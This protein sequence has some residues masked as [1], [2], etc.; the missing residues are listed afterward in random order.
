MVKT[1][2]TEDRCFISCVFFLLVSDEESTIEEQE[3][4]EGETDHKSELNDLAK[5][6]LC[7]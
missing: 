4:M 7:L 5:D 3:G 1:V 6:G 2:K